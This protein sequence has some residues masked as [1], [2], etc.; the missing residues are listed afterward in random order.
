MMTNFELNAAFYDLLVDWDRRLNNELPFF[1]D[2]FGDTK[3]RMILDVA[4]GTGR[5][6]LEFARL[7][8]LVTGI[9]I[10]SQMI[11]LARKQINS[12]GLK[13]ENRLRF[14]AK[15][16][17]DLIAESSTIP[18][19]FDFIDCIGN[20]LALS[21]TQDAL[22]KTMKAFFNR[23]KVGGRLII[24]LVNYQSKQGLAHWAGPMVKRSDRSGQL[25]YFTKLFDRV[26]P[27]T[28]KMTI[29]VLHRLSDNKW[30]AE[31]AENEL[32]A[33]QVTDV[34]SA[35]RQ[36]GFTDWEVFGDYQKSRFDPE[37]SPDIII[38]ATR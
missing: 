29:A 5:H 3:G 10:D 13:K 38:V 25:F 11:E 33:F 14:L 26:E 19:P 23:L 6:A 22:G 18:G 30:T 4:C 31:F 24:Q 17:E 16:F 35:V 2:L 20:S 7:G 8:H 9:D 28:L 34:E 32:Q 21:P 12:L 1:Q 15:S 37:T 36:A 27:S